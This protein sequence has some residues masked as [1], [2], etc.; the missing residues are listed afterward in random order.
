MN[1]NKEEQ[2]PLTGHPEF[3][4]LLNQMRQTHIEKSAGYAGSDNPDPLANFRNCEELG[5]PAFIGAWIR[6]TD[7][8]VRIKNIMRDPADELIGE[9][10]ADT[11]IDAASYALI[12]RILYEEDPQRNH[13]FLEL[14]RGVRLAQ[15][16][17]YNEYK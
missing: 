1:D 5:I 8:V 4:N 3:Y 17:D 2:T 14:L 12:M 9:S 13:H 16:K 15:D 11:L 7:K 10:L 6:H